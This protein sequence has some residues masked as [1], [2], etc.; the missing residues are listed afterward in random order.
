MQLVIFSLYLLSELLHLFVES[1]LIAQICALVLRDFVS[2]RLDSRV[3]FK[4]ILSRSLSILQLT[5]K[6]LKFL[7]THMSSSLHLIISARL[8][9]FDHFLQ[10]FNLYSHLVIPLFELPYEFF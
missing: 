8:E 6:P 7:S 9:L 10:L 5:L 1:F 2:L 3:F 4:Y